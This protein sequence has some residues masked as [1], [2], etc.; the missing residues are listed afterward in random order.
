MARTRARCSSIGTAHRTP[1]A[2][3]E[4][5]EARRALEA[6][7]PSGRRVGAGP[8]R[9]A[10][11]RMA[12]LLPARP[13][14]GADL[15]ARAGRGRPWRAAAPSFSRRSSPGVGQRPVLAAT[16]TRRRGWSARRHLQAPDALTRRALNRLARRLLRAQSSDEGVHH[17]ERTMVDHAVRGT[18][19]HLLASFA[20]TTRSARDR[21]TKQ[22]PPRSKRRRTSSPSS[23]TGCTGGDA[24]PTS[25]NR[26]G[27]VLGNSGRDRSPL[28]GREAPGR[29]PRSRV[30]GPG[31]PD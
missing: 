27:D 29:L 9:G 11:A 2:A 23:T 14:A 22:V 13:R 25:R 6:S 3:I 19:E 31:A 1:S 15:P 17:D 26:G 24:R 20:S 10:G 21:S 12:R 28:P 18:K 7:R 16:C 4:G 5:L 30:D 8:R